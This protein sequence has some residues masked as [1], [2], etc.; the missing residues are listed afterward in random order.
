MPDNYLNGISIVTALPGRKA[1][2]VI[3][4]SNKYMATT[5][6]TLPVVG[7]RGEGVY[8]QDVDGNVFLDYTSGISVTNVGYNNKYVV[9]KVEEQ[10]HKLWHFAG[11][12]FYTEVYVEAAKLLSEVTPGKFKKKVFYANSGTESVEAL[13]KIAKAYTKRSQFIG[14]IGGF[15]GRTH[16]SL[17]FTASKAL[18]RKG[19]FSYMPG[20]E[21][22]PFPDP[23]RNPFGIDGYEHPSELINS[24]LDYIESY[25]FKTYLHPDDVGGI[26]VEPV[27]GEGG[28]IVPPKN[29]FKELKK[30]ADD[31]NIP[32]LLDEVQTGFGRTGKFFASEYFG[33]EPDAMALAKSIASGIPMGAVV[34]KD[35]MN[36]REHGMHSNTY[37]GN[38]LASAACIATIETMKKMNIVKNSEEKGRYMKKRLLELQEKYE[39][40]GDV[41]GLGLMLAIDFVKNRKSKEYHQRL[42]DEVIEGSFRN[43]LL[44][45]STGQGAIRLI[46]PLIINEREID[47]GIEVL[48]RSIRQSL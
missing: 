16:G 13:I 28:Y 43:G 44:L 10:L 5:T 45:L 9:K 32:L 7:Q 26:L 39:P 24:I 12:D 15:H 18:Q 36:F 46:P 1:K 19:F 31:Y 30:L 11:T 48:D 4:M 41:R 25:V 22:V 40:I 3:E 33:I 14:F 20:V 17:S 34:M 42:R 38:P 21:H 27:Q 37:G 2:K 23:Y 35:K 29:F 47:E 6:Q 8:I